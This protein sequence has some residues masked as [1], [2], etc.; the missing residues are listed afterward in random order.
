MESLSTHAVDFD[1]YSCES[2]IR[3]LLGPYIKSPP[4]LPCLLL[5]GG[6][7]VCASS[8]YSLALIDK[9]QRVNSDRQRGK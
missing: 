6:Y 3:S 1:L 2:A 5:V 7:L 9:A 8:A 4:Q